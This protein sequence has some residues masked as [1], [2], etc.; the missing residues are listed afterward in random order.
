[1]KE[2]DVLGRIQELCQ[3]RNWTYYRLAKESGIPYSTLNT[4]LRKTNA[5]T[6]HTLQKLCS[7]FGITLEQFFSSDVPVPELTEEQRAVLQLWD[8]L[9]ATSQA[10]ASAYIQGLKDRQS[11]DENS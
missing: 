1:M 4:M 9:D 10:L 6:V 3:S 5:P 7:G 11:S 8:T 2:F